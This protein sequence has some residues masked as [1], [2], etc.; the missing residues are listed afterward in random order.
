MENSLEKCLLPFGFVVYA[1]S[2]KDFIGLERKNQSVPW[3][4]T[5]HESNH[6]VRLV[7]KVVG[8]CPFRFLFLMHRCDTLVVLSPPIGRQDSACDASARGTNLNDLVPQIAGDNFIW[9]TR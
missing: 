9:V 5:H 6:G 3:H 8:T 4:H 2:M 7:E 1:Y